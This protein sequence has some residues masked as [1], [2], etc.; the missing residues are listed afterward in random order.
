MTTIPFRIKPKI[1]GVGQVIHRCAVC[2]E[3]IEDGEPVFAHIDGRLVAL[4]AE[5]KETDKWPQTPA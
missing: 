1:A 5:H 4:H 2:G 3:P